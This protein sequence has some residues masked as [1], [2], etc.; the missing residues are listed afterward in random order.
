MDKEYRSI[1]SELYQHPELPISYDRIL[2]DTLKSAIDLEKFDWQ[3]FKDP[4]LRRQY[5]LLQ[6]EIK[7]PRSSDEFIKT[8][9]IL[10]SVGK[11]KIICDTSKSPKCD[12]ISF[13]RDVKPIITNSNNYEQ[14]K[15]F[16]LEWR[17]NLPNDFKNA[18]NYYLQYYQNISVTKAP[19][20]VW[21]EQ[22]EMPNFIEELGSVMDTIK[23]LYQQVHAHLREAL[24]D[25]F[26]SYIINSSLIP[27]PLLEQAMYQSWKKESVLKNPFPQKKLP[28]LQQELRGKRLKPM[29]LVEISE[30]YYNSM[31]FTPLTE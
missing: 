19:S 29:N 20:E 31:G 6:R 15:Y 17:Q 11:R 5:E 7:Y 26:G 21:Y 16:W 4:L 25:K 8:T 13:V 28:N 9:S 27:H 12:Q 18:V 30:Q 3:S 10:K 24:K 14:I 2:R 23:P 1:S 22:Y